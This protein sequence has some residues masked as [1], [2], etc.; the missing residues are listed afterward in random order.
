MK[1]AVVN[2]ADSGSITIGAAGVAEVLQNVR[3]ILSTR[4]GTV[5]FDRDFGV[6]WDMVDLPEPQARAELVAEI[7][8]KVHQYEPRATVTRVEWTETRAE[9]MSGRLCPAVTLEVE[10]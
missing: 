8:D 3:V 6:S 2:M 5:P 10:L 4:V 9:A 1:T 7:F